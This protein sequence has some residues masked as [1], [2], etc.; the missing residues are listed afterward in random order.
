M[1]SIIIALIIIYFDLGKLTTRIVRFD[2]FSFYTNSLASLIQ[3]EIQRK[4]DLEN[5][6][7]DILTIKDILENGGKIRNFTVFSRLILSR[8]QPIIEL[9]RGKRGSSS[10]RGLL[11]SS[12][13]SALG[14]Q[15]L[16]DLRH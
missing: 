14:I 5:S 6:Q 4:P 10:S 11:L 8:W 16:Q 3:L 12:V 9:F 15:N 7:I 2:V 13:T 1:V